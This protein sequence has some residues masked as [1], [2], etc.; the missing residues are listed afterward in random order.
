MSD[1]KQLDPEH[2]DGCPWCDD[3]GC[4]YC[5]MRP[6]EVVRVTSGVL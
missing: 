6:T 4:V 5:S 3:R 1:E 2:I